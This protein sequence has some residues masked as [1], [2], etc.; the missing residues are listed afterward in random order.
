MTDR[1]DV[2]I[3]DD[4]A[5][6]N[7]ML[8]EFFSG[9]GLRV[10]TTEWAAEA[11]ELAR[12]H[13]PRVVLLDIVMPGMDGL[14][15][16]HAIKTD[17]ELGQTRVLVMSSKDFEVERSRAKA[18]GAE[19]FL[20]KPVSPEALLRQIQAML[21]ETLTVRMWGTRGS[22]PAPGPETLRY[23]G[24]TL[25]VTVRLSTGRLL[26]FDAGSG[27]KRLGRALIQEGRPVDADILLTHFHWD[28]IQGLP[29]FVP[30]YRMGT[31]L[32]IYGCEYAD[33]KLHQ[34]IANQMESVYFPVPLPTLAA[35][36]RFQPL[37]EGHYAFDDFELDTLYLQ[38]PGTT[39]GYRLRRAG[40]TLAYVTDNELG[41][42]EGEPTPEVRRVVEFSRGADLLIHD[43]QFTRAQYSAVRG[44][45]HS[46]YEDV[47]R[48]GALARVRRLCFFHHDPDRTDDE[49]DALVAAQRRH[50]AEIGSAVECFAA[51][52]GMVIDL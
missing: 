31:R 3:V 45:G 16:C 32:R 4:D 41:I 19:G 23:G 44:W 7:G 12:L 39:I 24:N 29:F 43:T 42:I 8:A 47:V 22:I 11:V 14:T 15:V 6:L 36:I 49:I 1:A 27:I 35:D 37:T 38:H 33:I 28:H 48:L 9:Q 30:A 51:Q 21:A 52:E 13:Q 26:I 10:V 18:M 25:C 40:K 34:I 2:L 50:L 5:A 17:P 20:P 46:C